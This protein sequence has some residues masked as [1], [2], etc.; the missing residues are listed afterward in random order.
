MARIVRTLGP[1]GYRPKYAVTDE[2]KVIELYEGPLIPQAGAGS[3]D[4]YNDEFVNIASDDLPS[5]LTGQDIY[6]GTTDAERIIW[7]KDQM[8]KMQSVALVY[9]EKIKD[10][11]KGEP[12]L[13]KIVASALVLVGGKLLKA[14]PVVGAIVA[15][16]G[17]IVQFLSK[18]TSDKIL[19]YKK[20]K[21]L[22]WSAILTTLQ[23]QYVLYDNE[24]KGLE[25]K[26]YI[27]AGLIVAIVAVLAYK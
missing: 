3:S 17:L 9:V 5:F 11:A 14:Q 26:K 7:L 20:E 4:S 8:T 25:A 6:K 22:K 18:S 15:G 13:A 12:D 19:A 27:K 23:N 24:L 2:G 1:R 21:I 16:A 10:M